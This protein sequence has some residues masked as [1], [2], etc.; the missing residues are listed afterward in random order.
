MSRMSPAVSAMLGQMVADLAAAGIDPDGEGVY[1]L[2]FTRPYCHA[3]HYLGWSPRLMRRLL[4]HLTG[5][6]SPLVAAVVA[7][8]ITVQLARTW[9]GDRAVERALKR[10]KHHRVYCPLCTASRAARIDDQAA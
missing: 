7:S 8:G 9:S 2:H 1:L 3:Q 5:R 10:R 6:G 4:A